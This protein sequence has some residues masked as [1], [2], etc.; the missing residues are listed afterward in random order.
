MRRLALMIA[1]L[2]LLAAEAPGLALRYSGVLGQS[3]PAGTEPLRE[4]GF[5]GCF[6][7]DGG[8]LWGASGGKLLRFANTD[9]RWLLAE[10]VA[11][12]SP[13]VKPRWSGGRAYFLA[14][15]TL[16]S[17]DPKDKTFAEIA[18]PPPRT[19]SFC[20]LP[21]GKFAF[22]RR[23]GQVLG[24]AGELLLRAPPLDD[25]CFYNNICHDGGLLLGSYYPDN[26]IR[27][28]KP[29]GTL[30]TA[31]DWPL[32]V[33]AAGLF[34]LDAET[35][36]V[37]MGGKVFRLGGGS[38]TFPWGDAVFGLAKV[39]SGNMFLACSQGLV[40]FASDGTALG[41]LGGIPKVE[42]MAASDDGYLVVAVEHG[43][44]LLRLGV[45]DNPDGVL[46]A[47]AAW[48]KT[49]CNYQSKA[50]ALA[51][52]GAQY[53]VL[54]AVEGVLWSFDFKRRQ[55]VLNPWTA[56]TPKATFTS[57]SALAYGDE[58][59]WI[60]DAAGLW[61]T[62]PAAPNFK[63]NALAFAG[64]VLVAAA[65]DGIR[66]HDTTG[67]ERWRLPPQ[68]AS[69]AA[70]GSGLVAASLPASGE[71]V[72]LDPREGKILA[73]LDAA[74]IPGGMKPGALA[75]AGP[76]LFVYDSQGCRVIRLKINQ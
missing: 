17:F 71:L 19:E 64:N 74:S 47:D 68:A 22:L 20:A 9:G 44:R 11:A 13:V 43:Q 3:Q 72:L 62:L 59:P 46:Q 53:L 40:E 56:L 15:G 63:A 55:H 39:P 10:T 23:D 32:P 24:M 54:D 5:T 42:C 73:R 38:F 12:P 57:P 7:D 28:F 66:G 61:K 8:S 25:G 6:V 33:F 1:G 4:A 69:L 70:C 18:A 21:G 76:W 75:A 36:V 52:D 30:D 16:R 51:W 37:A 60:V 41:R 58:R 45:D 67:A 35:W 49:G 29:D 27:R 50:V 2:C 65:P 31:G 26:K 48:W 14:A 34:K